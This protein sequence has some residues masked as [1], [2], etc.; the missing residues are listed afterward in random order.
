MKIIGNAGDKIIVEITKNELAH[1]I[2]YSSE[3]TAQSNLGNGW[4]G[5]DRNYPIDERIGQIEALAGLP[6][7]MKSFVQAQTELSKAVEAIK[8][9][10]DSTE[11]SQVKPAK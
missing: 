1:M 9:L 2:G 10:S 11:F 5:Y 8:K 3:Y 6:R 7:I 4:A